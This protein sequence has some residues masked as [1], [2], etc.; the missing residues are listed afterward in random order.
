MLRLAPEQHNLTSEQ[1]IWQ[2]LAKVANNCTGVPNSHRD[3]G[4]RDFGC[5][6]FAL[7]MANTAGRD[8][9]AVSGQLVMVDGSLWP[10]VFWVFF[11][12]MER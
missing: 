3:L 10:L 5:K 12:I 1:S 4:L 7:V 8:S 9:A 2:A 11:L 6:F